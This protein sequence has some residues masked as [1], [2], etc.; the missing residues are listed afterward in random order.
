MSNHPSFHEEEQKSMAE[1]EE[2]NSRTDFFIF[3]SKIESR[4][5]LEK[6]LLS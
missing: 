2:T 5:T 4:L 6:N 1:E 3:N